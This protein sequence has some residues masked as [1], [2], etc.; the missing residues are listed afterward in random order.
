MMSPR[1]CLNMKCC[2]I[3]N[4]NLLGA[5]PLPDFRGVFFEAPGTAPL[6][7]LIAVLPNDGPNP[8]IVFESFGEVGELLDF[9]IRSD[10]LFTP[11][12]NITLGRYWVV[13]DNI[14]RLAPINSSIEFFDIVPIGDDLFIFQQGELFLEV[15]NRLTST[16]F[17]LRGTTNRNNAVEVEIEDLPPI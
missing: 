14:L 7:G 13:A 16:A 12:Q 4:M 11:I 6:Q 10:N 5:C 15:G 3:N 8:R 9:A 2:K 1:I 17:E